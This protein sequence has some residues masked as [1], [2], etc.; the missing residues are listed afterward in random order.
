MYF[1]GT[2]LSFRFALIKFIL[3][4]AILIYITFWKLFWGFCITQNW[5]LW[6]RIGYFSILCPYFWNILHAAWQLS[7]LWCGMSRQFWNCSRFHLIRMIYWLMDSLVSAA[8]S[9]GFVVSDTSSSPCIYFLSSVIP[10][11]S[12]GTVDKLVLIWRTVHYCTLLEDIIYGCVLSRCE[13]MTRDIIL[14]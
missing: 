5:P 3:P 11:P 4:K 14:L 12:I 2:F 9:A 7:A 10:S 6:T 8:L 13:N 1:S